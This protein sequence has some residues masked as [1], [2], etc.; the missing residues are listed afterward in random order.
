[1]VQSTPKVYISYVRD[2]NEH[3]EWVRNLAERL[4]RDG[5]DAILDQ[6]ALSPGDHIQQKQEQW[7]RESEAI[8]LVLT[9]SYLRR[10]P[11]PRRGVGFEVSLI[12]ELIDT[13]RALS[14]HSGRHMRSVT[15]W[16]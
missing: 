3:N 16:H 10:M 9:D 2:S 14:H 6:W 8:V 4:R 7:V 15:C 11:D 5:V 12:Q 13:D 1:M